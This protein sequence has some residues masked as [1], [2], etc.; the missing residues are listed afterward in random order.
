MRS[1]APLPDHPELTVIHNSAWSEYRLENTR[2]C[3]G[4]H[5]TAHSVFECF[6][7][8]MVVCLV[9][10]I[11]WPIF[12]WHSAFKAGLAAASTLYAYT[13][14]TQVLRESVVVLRSLGL[15]L[16]TQRG[17]PFIP[18]FTSRRFIP[19]T[20]LRDFVINEGLRGWS[21]HYYLAVIQQSSNG[22]VTIDVPFENIMP[23][24]PILL[25]VYHGVHELLFDDTTDSIAQTC[26]N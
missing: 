22:E 25:E 19:F 2:L 10:A 24:F 7:L 12:A 11:L 1:A 13:R 14:C 23:R 3:R 21:V 17:L 26:N 15:Q 8:D 5:R 18:L 16:E 6:W 4:A 9:V 20:T